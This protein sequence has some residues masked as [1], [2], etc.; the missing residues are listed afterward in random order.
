MKGKIIEQVKDTIK[1]YDG[2]TFTTDE[3]VN[4]LLKTAPDL[5]AATIQVTIY[6][7]LVKKGFIKKAGAV[8]RK[9]VFCLNRKTPAVAQAARTHHHP[10]LR[11]QIDIIINGFENKFTA[12][13][14]IE[15]LKKDNGAV[16]K[17]TVYATI[18]RDFLAKGKIIKAGKRDGKTIYIKK[19]A[20]IIK[21][22]EPIETRSVFSKQFLA[23]AAALEKFSMQFIA[24]AMKIHFGIENEEKKM[25]GLILKLKKRKQISSDGYRPT[26]YKLLPDFYLNNLCAMI[27]YTEIVPALELRIMQ[28]FGK[29]CAPSDNKEMP[30]EMAAKTKKEKLKERLNGYENRLADKNLTII[31]LKNNN[32]SLTNRNKDLINRLDLYKSQ[33]HNLRQDNAGLVAKIEAM[34]NRKKSHGGSFPLSELISNRQ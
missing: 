31:S 30:V 1:A 14:I 15:K 22:A 6:R 33:I 23:T 5:K 11:L 29:H 28:Q 16:L 18:S 25:M 19:A 12:F 17:Q 7:D 2:E 34:R 26:V 27:E 20:N 13:D 21:Y 10:P 9:S 24:H 3:I 32:R 8:G 4:K